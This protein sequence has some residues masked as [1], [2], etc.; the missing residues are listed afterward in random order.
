MSVSLLCND[1]VNMFFSIGINKCG[2]TP[3]ICGCGKCI[4]VQTGYTCKCEPGFKLSALQTNSIGKQHKGSARQTEQV[5]GNSGVLK[6]KQGHTKALQRAQWL[7]LSS[8]QCRQVLNTNH[9]AAQKPWEIKW[10]KMKGIR[11]FMLTCSVMPDNSVQAI[12]RA[13]KS[14][15]SLYSQRPWLQP[16]LHSV[17]FS[18]V[19]WECLY[20]RWASKSGLCMRFVS[21]N[22]NGL[23]FFPPRC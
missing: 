7:C 5:R 4:P 13:A 22:S 18:P 12:Q 20:C 14:L 19:V 8:E 11:L 15:W 16:R 6:E 2:S 3:N 1:Y 21:C 23:C 9:Y 17:G 10:A